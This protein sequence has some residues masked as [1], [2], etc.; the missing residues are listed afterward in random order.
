[1]KHLE[2]DCFRVRHSC[3]QCQ[4]TGIVNRQMHVCG[5]KQYIKSLLGKIKES[6]EC[7]PVEATRMNRIFSELDRAFEVQFNDN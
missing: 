4:Q 2:Y 6:H 5:G 3:L 7:S 1:M